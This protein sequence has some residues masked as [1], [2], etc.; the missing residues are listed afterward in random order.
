AGFQDYYILAYDAEN[1]TELWKYPLP[2]GLSATPMTYVSPKT[3]K[4]YVLISVGG[5]PYSKDIGYYF[6]AF[7]LKNRD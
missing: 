2:V 5:A 3:V 6:F 7:S 4:Q 1:G